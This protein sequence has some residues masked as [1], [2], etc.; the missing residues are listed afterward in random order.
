MPFFRYE[1]QKYADSV[2]TVL[3]KTFYQ[4]GFGWYPYSSN[5]NIKA[6]FGRKEFPNDPKTATTNE[7]TVQVQVFYY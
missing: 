3:N 7:Y 6:G 1:Q 4:A 5:F 2:N